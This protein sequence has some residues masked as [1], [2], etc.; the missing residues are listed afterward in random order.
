M[1]WV[2]ELKLNSNGSIA[3]HKARLVAK[4]FLQKSGVDYKEVFVPVARIET[5]RL[6]I[7][8]ASISNW[9]LYHLDVKSAFLNGPL[10]EEVFV[11]QPPGFEQKGK[12]K[13]V[14]KLNKTLY[15]LKQAPRC[16]NKRIGSFFC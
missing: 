7:S 14:Y 10:G 1:K 11:T 3:K 2:F 9:C 15:D 6:V 8:L 4:G 5:I 12:E 16:W 13:Y